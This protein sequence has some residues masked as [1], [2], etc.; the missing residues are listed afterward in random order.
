LTAALKEQETA[1]T[2]L[3][4][5]RTALLQGRAA[6]EVEIELRTSVEDVTNSHE[7]ARKAHAETVIS[8]ALAQA[9]EE[10]AINRLH[11]AD[12][13]V[14]QAKLALD[15]ALAGLGID[16]QKLE[17]RLVHDETWIANQRKDLDS[18]REEVTRDSATCDERQRGL[19][20]HSAKGRPE[21]DREVA[22][23]RVASARAQVDDLGQKLIGL[24][25]KQQQDDDQGIGRSSA[26]AEVHAQEKS[27]RVWEQ[28]DEVIGSADG[29]K[30][31][32]FAQSLAFDALLREAN[33]HLAD[34]APRYRLMSVPGAALE[35]QVAD[36]DL[37]SEVR[38]I[39]SLSGGEIFLVSLALALGLSGISTRA[40][41]AQTLFIDEGFGTLDRDTLD[42]AMVALENL[43]ATGRTVGII[44]HV[45]E[46]Q[47]RFGAQVRVER[48]GCGKSRVVI[49]RP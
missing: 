19:D 18:L 46:L 37:A 9:A 15:V 30:F 22:Q 4:A 48:V 31:R 6:L 5:K 13:E 41:Q 43:Q 26:Q 7:M 35:L 45:P 49:L 14:A 42:H 1:L 33:A 39:N 34:L 10:S 23:A 25:A 17:E 27:S 24:R 40:T 32:V 12:Q 44:S 8:R 3:Q 2:D 36:Q 47:E 29:K 21:G 11:E 28:L 20:E 38:T 16:Q